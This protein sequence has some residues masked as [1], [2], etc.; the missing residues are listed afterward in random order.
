MW[1]TLEPLISV[2]TPSSKGGRH[3]TVKG[4]AA[5]NRILQVS[6]TCI[7]WEDLRQELGRD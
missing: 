3:C 1:T 6:R 5:L 2:C 7:P 4:R